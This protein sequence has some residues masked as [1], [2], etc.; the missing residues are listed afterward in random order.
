MLR[1]VAHK[2]AAAALQYYTEALRREDYYSEGQEVAGKWHGKA[3]AMLGLV[4]AVTPEGFAALVEN[5]HPGTGERLTARMKTDRVVG[6]DLNFHA[7]K[8]LS[9]LHAL[10]GDDAIVK[11]FRE[12]VAETMGEIEAQAATRVRKSGAQENR[13]TGNFA[14]AEFVHFTARPVGGI[15]DPH[16]HVHCFAFNATF[17]AEEG[18]WKAANFRDIKADAPY[19]AAVFH[20]RLTD[21]L[22]ALGYGIERT[23]QGWEVTGIPRSVIDK[24]SRR[25]EQINRL[26]REKG[27]TD[28]KEKDALGAASREG[29]RHGLTY[30]DL[31]A[32]WGVRLTA[33]EKVAIFKVGLDKTGNGRAE[34][35]TPARALDE[36]CEKLFAKNS[37]VDTNR[38]IAEA[39]H[40]GV[41][42]VTPDKIWREFGRR[43]MVVRKI[44]GRVLCT[45]VDVLAE[46]VALINFVRSGRGTRAP[47][48]GRNVKTEKA[49]LSAE[50]NAAVRH[51]LHSRDQVMAI[52]GAAG[53]GKTRLMREAVVAAIEEQ[54]FKVFVFAPSASA[55]RETLREEGFSNAQTVA[56]L[57]F[58]ERLQEETQGQVIWIDEAGQIGAE[59]MLEILRIAGTST[60]V[61]LTGDTAQHAPVP[62]G[63]TF[64]IMQKYAGMKVAEVTEIRRQEREGYR[65]AVASLCKGDLRTAFSRLD[66]LG[67]IV[68]I[69]NDAERYRQLAQDYLALSHKD[70]VPLV[71]S[72]THAESA[73]VTDAIREAKREAGKLGPEKDFV[74]YHNLQWENPDK[75]RVE[76]YEPGLLVQF[77]QNVHGICRGDLFRVIG[78]DEKGAVQMVGANGRQTTLPLNE[79]KRF[80][81]FEAREIKLATGDR[82]RITLGGKS[83]DGRRLNNGNVFTIAR[84]TPGGKII[85]S[86]GA[87]LEPTHGHFTYGYCQTSHSSQSKSVRDVLVAQSTSSFLASSREQFYV[88]VSRGKESI[89]IY[90]DDRRGLQEA[91]GNS[92]QRRSGLELAEFSARE[93]A[94]IMNDGPGSGQ[95]RDLVRSRK[96]GEVTEHVKNLLRERKQEGATKSETMDFRKYIAQRRANAGP[97]GRNRSIGYSG[98]P[99]KTPKSKG[100]NQGQPF[101]RQTEPRVP[102][103]TGANDNKKPE[104]AT[105]QSRL[106]KGYEAAKG[107]FKKVTE[108]LKTTADKV[109]KQ[110][111]KL[112]P[113]SNGAKIAKHAMKQRAVDAGKTAQ[114]KAKIVKQKAP[115]P[116]P[117]RTR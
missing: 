18:R 47:F 111:A 14:W 93:V 62:R 26:A 78:V 86:N 40:F 80:Q 60:P 67:A 77:N 85:L 73:K 103:K 58:N 76:N 35:I 102:H 87:V 52:R 59:D 108:R 45:S 36:A 43:D 92:S 39:L 64:R 1:V 116:A 107:H 66:D 114:K 101:L 46:E 110:G 97:E 95:W 68:E 71:V 38:L 113:K 11:A 105:R 90:T 22:V 33:D 32:A 12:A 55:S 72:P 99:G 65:N 56:H 31:L 6:Y 20:S 61:I 3:A 41:G 19:S 28:P 74:R 81:V 15:P 25:S 100:Q 30:P 69:K 50:Q 17:D 5:R 53:V 70:S 106:A 9:V 49:E 8:S 34:K 79:A 24:F 23:R 104:A 13:V 51:I 75:R 91:V 42:Q 84:F 63:D 10:T 2:S 96:T 89:R 117:K 112:L 115:A 21:K 7:P 88:S 82:I 16:L 29:K 94:S 109:K 98:G 57:L 83:A 4:G 44:D 37:V 48:V 54:G 27:I